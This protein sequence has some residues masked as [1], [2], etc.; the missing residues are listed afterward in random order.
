MRNLLKKRFDPDVPTRESPE[1]GPAL[2]AHLLWSNALTLLGFNLLTVLLCIPIVSAP[3]ALCALNRVYGLV[4]RRGYGF[5]REAYFKEFRQSFFRSLLLGLLYGGFFLS[6]VICILYGIAVGADGLGTYSMIFGCVEIAVAWLLSG[7]SFIL[8]SVQDLS[9]GQLL[10]NTIS[11][12][13]LELRCSAAMVLTI[14]LSAGLMWWTF[15]FCVFLLIFFPGLTQFIL[16]W[17][18]KEPIQRRIADKAAEA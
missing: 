4:I 14:F 8:L 2:F 6:G 13:L 1:K 11:M 12:M 9:L 7:W 18:T 15:P 17:L 10:R 5:L 3:A 16:C